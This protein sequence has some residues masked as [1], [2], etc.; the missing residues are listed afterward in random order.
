MLDARL[1]TPS[2]AER[3]WAKPKGGDV[4][5]CWVWG[6]ALTTH[7]YGQFWLRGRYVGSHRVAWVAL[8]GEIPEGLNPDHLCKN[9]ACVNPWH[10]DL[11]TQRVN[12]LRGGSGDSVR[13]RSA[14]QTACL[15]GHEYT[16]ENTRVGRS[17]ARFCRACERMRADAKRRTGSR[18][19]PAATKGKK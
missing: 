9:R 14:A 12:V 19:L 5:E 3:F 4:E 6:D 11:V 2:E 18:R 1:L 8:R 10:L 16:P 17:G 7:G 15:R 13:A